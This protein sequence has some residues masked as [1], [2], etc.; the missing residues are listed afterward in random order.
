MELSPR[1]KDATFTGSQINSAQD[2]E[3]S[4]GGR[5]TSCDSQNCLIHKISIGILAS[6]KVQFSIR[7]KGSSNLHILWHSDGLN[8]STPA[9]IKSVERRW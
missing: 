2:W 8:L 7:L 6:D 3:A 9:E 5:E 1:E 4:T